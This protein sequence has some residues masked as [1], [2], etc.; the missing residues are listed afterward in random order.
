MVRGE[1]IYQYQSSTGIQVKTSISKDTHLI[2][3]KN[4]QWEQNTHE[5][6]RMI[7]ASRN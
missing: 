6:T 5:I 4:S 2:T 7:G 1:G 3:L